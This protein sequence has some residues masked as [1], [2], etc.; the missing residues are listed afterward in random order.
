MNTINQQVKKDKQEKQP[1]SVKQSGE[2]NGHEEPVEE[3][4]EEIY[5]Q[6]NNREIP[7]IDMPSPAP[8]KI[9]KN[10]PN[11]RKDS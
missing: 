3:K 8:K 4:S 10:I 11:L 5:K 9:E 1:F 6:S 7:D 2:Y